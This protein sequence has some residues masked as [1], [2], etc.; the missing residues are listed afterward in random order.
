M[1]HQEAEVNSVA[2]AS[3]GWHSLGYVA[4][5]VAARLYTAATA[6]NLRAGSAPL[7]VAFPPSV[8]DEIENLVQVV[9]PAMMLLR[10]LM[11]VAGGRPTMR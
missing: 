11:L 7:V 9:I 10:L 3:A 1:H 6:Q 5:L 8:G 2:G 4:H